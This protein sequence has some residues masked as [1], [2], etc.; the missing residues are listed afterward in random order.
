MKTALRWCQAERLQQDLKYAARGIQR[1]PGYAATVLLTLALGIGANTAVF[2][3]LNTLILRPLPVRAPHELVEPLSAYP[4]DPRLNIFAWK[5]YEQFRDQNKVF[6]GITGVSPSRFEIRLSDGDSETLDG[7]YVVGDFFSMLGVKAAAG[8]VIESQDD[9]L[10][11]TGAAVA[12]LSWSYWKSRFDLDPDV[13]GRQITVASAPATVIGVAQRGFFGLQVGEKQDI[14]IPAAMEPMIQTPSRRTNGDLNLALIARLGAGV[15]IE[16]AQAEMRVLDRQRVDDLFRTSPN[17]NPVLEQIRLDLEPAAAGFSRLRDRFQKPLMALMAVV[18]LLL[19]LAC[20]NIAGMALAKAAA[21]EREMALRVSLGAGRFSLMRQ[22]WTE[23][24]LLSALGAAA[25]FLVAYHGAEA[26]LHI[27]ASGRPLPGTSPIQIDLQLDVRVLAFTAA[28]TV[29]TGLLFG[30]VP[31]LRAMRTAPVTSL[32]T[33]GKAAETRA[34]RL[35]GK[36]LVAAQVALSVVILTAA[37]L[38]AG[39]LS[40]LRSVGLGFERNNVLLVTTDPS[41]SGYSNENLSALYRELLSRLDAIPGVLSASL[42][43]ATPIS[44]AAASRFIVAEGFEERHED[45]RYVMLNRAGP[46]YFETIGTPLVAGRE[47]EA[48]ELDRVAIV[49]HA[50]AAHYF[51]A[52]NPIG[53]RVTFEGETEPYEIV[54]LVGDAKY[55]DLRQSAPRTVYL[56]A[57]RQGSAPARNFVLRTSIDPA[58]VT[59]AARATIEDALSEVRIGKITTLAAQMDETLVPERLVAGFASLFSLVAAML[60]AVGLY[61]LLAYFVTRRRSEIGVRMAV[62]A[63][64]HAVTWMV[65]RDAMVIVFIGLALGAPAAIWSG[66]LATHVFEQVPTMNMLTILGAG[67]TMLFVAFLASYGPARRAARVDPIKAIQHD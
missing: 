34:G 48:Q 57:F 61:G 53:K 13:V 50:L 24:L 2:S 20:N 37:G 41:G 16:Q 60:A 17:R 32:R 49:N 4:G 56:P 3:L 28:V 39:H 45:R 64:S 47:F 62:G 22:V 44:G 66:R 29:L 7:G 31:A 9:Q 35:F 51:P 25:G 6:S 1:D 55:L 26:L 63:T 59:P 58:A 5:Y 67:A 15:S 38:F 21:R 19:L 42:V 36:G 12:V 43:G 23:S 30:T 11:S 54:G 8:R 18:A 33:A 10:G 14:W 52:E 40:N 65:L 46:Q 27:V